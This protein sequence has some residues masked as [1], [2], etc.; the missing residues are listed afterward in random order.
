[1]KIQVLFLLLGFFVNGALR[2]DVLK[3]D[4]GQRETF[5]K[6]EHLGEDHRDGDDRDDSEHGSSPKEKEIP[7]I[8]EGDLSQSDAISDSME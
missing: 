1:M 4:L 7:V 5:K 2:A 8:V 6:V 3:R